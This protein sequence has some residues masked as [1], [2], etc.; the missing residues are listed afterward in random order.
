MRRTRGWTGLRPMVFALGLVA[1]TAGSAQ[2]ASIPASP[3]LAYSTDG[4]SIGTT[5]VSGTPV[6]SFIH[7]VGAVMSPSNLSFGKF[8]VAAPASGQTT[9]YT[10]TPFTINLTAA[11]MDGSTTAPVLP[12]SP[13]ITLTGVLNGTVSSS[14]QSNVVATFNPLASTDFTTGNY[15]NTLG[16]PNSPLNLVPSTSNGGDTTAQAA[17][18][19]VYITPPPPSAV[20]EPSTL[21]LFAATVIGLGFRRRLLARRAA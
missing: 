16:L 19:S 6:I 15:I 11:P 5:G 1:A 10:N 12:T 18:S 17:L 2:A 7:T 8:E 9:T 21:A 3:V 20:P 13:L 4:S 14:N